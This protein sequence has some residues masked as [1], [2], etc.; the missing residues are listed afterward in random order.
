MFCLFKE[1]NRKWGWGVKGKSGILCRYKMN[2]KK[3]SSQR[4]RVGEGV[5]RLETWVWSPSADTH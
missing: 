5:G 2:Q 1:T 3:D 4:G